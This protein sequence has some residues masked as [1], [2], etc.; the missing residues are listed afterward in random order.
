[1]AVAQGFETYKELLLFLGTAGVVVPLFTRLK[2]SPVLGFLAAGVI[3]GPFLL[4]ALAR[5]IPWFS[6]VSIANAEEMSGPA[7]FGVAFL[8]FM[9]GLELSWERLV[10][11][12]KLIFG[13]G[14]LQVVLSSI[15]LGLIAFALGQSPAS[16]T[17]L[18]GALALSSTA[19]VLP[20]LAE[21]KRL[22]STTGR[23]SL[24][25]LLFQDLAVAPLLMMIALLDER[26][27]AGVGASLLYAFAPAAIA[28]AALVG[29][30]RLM[31]RP[32][33]QLV[34]S[35]KSNELFVAA[36]LFFVIGTGLITAATGQSMS[37]G[38]FVA[39]L[40]LAETEYRRQVQV[41]IQPF[42]GL[43]LGL[44]F[45]SVG[46][47][48]DLSY[49]IASPLPTFGV[50]C[51]LIVT[52]ALVL[53]PL[54]RGMGLPAR[55]AQQVAL[56]LSPG[57]EFA[58]VLIGAALAA[59]IVPASA[60]SMAMVAATLSMF[61]I[62]LMVRL[63]EK[64]AG[65]RRDEDADLAALAP[66]MVD[67]PARAI[68]VGYGRVG[69]LV[70]QLLTGHNIAYLAIDIDP[71]LVAR[72]RN[73]GKVIYYGG[74]TKLELLRRCRA[75]ICPDPRGVCA[76]TPQQSTEGPW[77]QDHRRWQSGRLRRKRSSPS[78]SSE[79]STEHRRLPSVDP[80]LSEAFY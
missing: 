37:L 9:I 46:A 5:D 15:A 79:S 36:C 24:A 40:L 32:L 66:T 52:K 49:V 70:G 38:A 60:G 31:L 10:R 77:A 56:I 28:L 61:A 22:N 76:A 43:L 8:L 1:M 39:G 27:G 20:S 19:L 12:R 18:G 16:A 41:T 65:H 59:N 58:L 73:R 71:A 21:R 30:G 7:E 48:L 72:E 23:A 6:A 45:I 33:F 80:P 3:L 64:I 34:A 74:A 55:V 51:G 17:V 25:V 11:M 29:I 53:L 54:A 78:V 63:S 57:G 2:L 62:P 42:Q 14:S 75:G 4:G 26:S 68:I 13:L 44:F 47:R 67:G 35:T 69:D 50:A